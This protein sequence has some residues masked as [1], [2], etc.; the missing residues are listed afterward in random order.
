MVYE[1][2]ALVLPETKK[3]TA[4][5][6]VS[7]KNLIRRSGRSPALPYPPDKQ[8]HLVVCPF[9]DVLFSFVLVFSMVCRF[10]T[11][12]LTRNKLQPP[13]GSWEIT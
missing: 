2:I 3:R 10:M 5:P 8:D 4:A 1:F 9:S 11:L 12:F 7:V 6:S 13:K